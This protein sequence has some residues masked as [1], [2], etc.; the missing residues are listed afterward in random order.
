MKRIQKYLGL[1]QMDEMERHILFRAQRNSYLFLVLSLTVWTFYESGRVY[2]HHTRLNLVPC[3]LLVVSVLI[4]SFSQLILTRAA[5]KGDEDS[6]ETGPL[7]RL[8]VLT[9]ILAAIL[10]AV[11]GAFV[12]LSVRI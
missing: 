8:V 4:Q 3:L 1:R 2:L 12:L 11:G 10:A 7:A 6:Y 9:C 5:V